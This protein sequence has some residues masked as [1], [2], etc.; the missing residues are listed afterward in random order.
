[1][2]R[3]SPADITSLRRDW[4][5]D[6]IDMRP[7]WGASPAVHTGAAAGATTL[8]IDGLGSGSLTRGDR[9]QIW[10]ASGLANA[11]TV[12]EDATITGGVASVYVTP[13]LAVAA[14]VADRVTVEPLKR[15]AFNRVFSRQFFSDVELEDFAI[16]AYRRWGRKIDSS[17]TPVE[18]LYQAIQLLSYKRFLLP[19]SEYRTA[20]K[21]ESPSLEGKTELDFFEREIGR[22]EAAVGAD[23]KGAMFIPCGRP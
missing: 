13:T 3:L 16:E 7:E 19:G 22:L 11:Y 2:G 15:S 14:V 17:D 4:I 12:S 20:L 21:I 18:M 1:M 23:T 6:E 10:S 8:V 9:F 5:G